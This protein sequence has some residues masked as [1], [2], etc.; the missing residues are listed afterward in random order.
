MKVGGGFVD[1]VDFT[2]SEVI[3]HRF[4][5]ISF[6]RSVKMKAQI[7]ELFLPAGTG[8][9]T[10]PPHQEPLPDLAVDPKPPRATGT[11]PIARLD[12]RGIPP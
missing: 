8:S 3:A 5:P 12:E 10:L 11:D 4:I 2:R 9:E 1:L 6:S 7:V